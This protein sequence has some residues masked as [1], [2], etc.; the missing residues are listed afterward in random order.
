M[1]HIKYAVLAEL[2]CECVNQYAL[3]LDATLFGK[4]LLSSVERLARECEPSVQRRRAMLE[5]MTRVAW[6]RAGVERSERTDECVPRT[7]TTE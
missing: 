5:E 4:D 3:V 6:E 2:V 7:L 1:Q